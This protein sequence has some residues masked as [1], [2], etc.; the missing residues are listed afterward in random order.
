MKDAK[1]LWKEVQDV[2]SK[3][4]SVVA[5]EV[6]IQPLEPVC[7][8]G[9]KLILLAVLKNAKASIMRNYSEKIR[10]AINDV[11]TFVTDFD[12]ITEDERQA[13]E[14][15]NVEKKEEPKENK[16]VFD[17]CFTFDNFVIG[18]S[19]QIAYAAAKAVAQNPGQQHNPLFIYGGVGLGKTHI[20]HAIGN[21]I[22]S[23]NPSAKI[24]YVTTAQFINDFI[25]SIRNNNDNENRMFREKYRDVDV[26]MLDDIQFIAGKEATQEALFHTFNDLYHF[27]KQIILSS[28]RHPK[29]LTFLDERLRS[30]FSYGLTC[31]ITAP[32][33]ETRIAIL[34]RK[35][36]AKKC[37]V[38]SDVLN[39]I[40][41]NINTNI[42]ELEGALNKV[43]FY[44]ALVG[45]EIDSVDIVK[46]A[47]KDEIESGSHALTIDTIVEK[48]CS[49]YNV[50][51]KDL[52]G[53]KRTSA[54]TEPRFM[55]IYLIN[56]ILSLPLVAIGEYFGGRDHATIIHARDKVAMALEKDMKTK[57]DFK[58]LKNMIMRK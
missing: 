10:N 58:N 2:L 24:L 44:A 13:Y 21:H 56:D 8:Y 22:Y 7:I 20:M 4:L 23:K 12:V 47:L 36:Y 25:D 52:V 34:E 45:R 18:G 55:C 50:S 19:N 30:R 31:D 1:Q 53:K 16:C 3:E 41:E 11:N 39:F 42:R 15:G 5:M 48:V 6:W 32:D 26:L 37:A 17:P 14:S 46:E 27:K 43:I 33:I 35:A 40:A 29:E 54:I 28:D 51:K 49:Y 9:N 38:P 57:I